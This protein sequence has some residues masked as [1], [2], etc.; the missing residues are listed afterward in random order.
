MSDPLQSARPWTAHNPAEVASQFPPEHGPSLDR[1]EHR[2]SD[3]ALSHGQER[4]IRREATCHAIDQAKAASDLEN[5]EE[6]RQ[7]ADRQWNQ[8]NPPKPWGWRERLTSVLALLPRLH[9][10]TPP[11]DAPALVASQQPARLASQVQEQAHPP[12]ADMKSVQAERR[13]QQA[14]EG[15]LSS[16]LGPSK[17][18]RAG[19]SKAAAQPEAAAQPSAKP[20]PAAKPSADPA[21]G[22]HPKPPASRA[23][24]RIKD[25]IGRF[26]QRGYTKFNLPEAHNQRGN[27]EA[28]IPVLEALSEEAAKL[29]IPYHHYREEVLDRE[30]C[31][32]VEGVW[33]DPKRDHSLN[34]HYAYLGEQGVVEMSE[35]DIRRFFAAIRQPHVEFRAMCNLDPQGRGFSR[36]VQD[37]VLSSAQAGIAHHEAEIPQPNLVR[38]FGREFEIPDARQRVSKNMSEEDQRSGFDIDRRTRQHAKVML[39]VG[40]HTLD[41]MGPSLGLDRERFL[42]DKHDK[43]FVVL[44]F[45]LNDWQ[46][47]LMVVEPEDLD[48]AREIASEY[49]GR[50]KLHCDGVPGCAPTIEPYVPEPGQAAIEPAG[51]ELPRAVGPHEVPEVPG[52]EPGLGVGALP[53]EDL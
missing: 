30:D 16:I 45:P 3:K 32:A 9:H 17:F 24:R 37:P 33:K 41:R 20:E 27:F 49:G 43:G 2:R 48:I 14:Q 6:D 18:K 23:E 50:V 31:V 12:L 29:D 11:S 52:V 40:S 13:L 35:A 53:K 22:V 42:Q 1:P 5:E 44:E 39:V 51:G 28:T 34:A 7:R 46:H 8:A 36:Y 15:D 26:V 10:P 4:Q 19:A 21:A 47:V 38:M 25:A